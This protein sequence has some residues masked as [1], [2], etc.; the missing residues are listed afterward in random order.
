MSGVDPEFLIG[1]GT[2]PPR[3]HQTYNFAKFSKK[4]LHEIEKI[5]GHGGL[6]GGGGHACRP[7]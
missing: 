6:G 2:D 1:G 7:S 5:L 3:G 4:N